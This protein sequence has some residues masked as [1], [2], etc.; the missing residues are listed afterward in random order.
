MYRRSL[1]SCTLIGCFMFMLSACQST[2]NV[3]LNPPYKIL[4]TSQFTPQTIESQ[5]EIFA[6]DDSIKGHLDKFLGAN[7]STAFRGKQLLRF[8]MENGDN[9]L[10]YQSGSNLT[11]SETF[12][13]LNANCLSLSILAHSMS[14]YIG[15]NS[16]FQQVHIPEF[17][18]RSQGYS[19]LTGHVNIK[20][21]P[22]QMRS[23]GNYT[24]IN[25]DT[26][27]IIVDFDPNS[28]RQHFKTSVITK[29]RI[30]SMFYN[31]KGALALINQDYDL[32]Y[33][34][35]KAAILIDPDY[36]AS[37][38]NIGVLYRANLDFDSAELA[39]NHAVALSENYT[40]SGNLALLYRLTNREADAIVIEQ[41]IAKKR[42]SNPYYHIM[43]G[44]EAY[45]S[46]DLASALIAYRHAKQL[47][48]K[49]HFS[50]FGIAKIYYQQGNLA[51][52]KHNLELARKLADFSFEKERYDSKLRWLDAMAKN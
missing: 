8:L 47:D 38:G 23:S 45:D 18:D 19:L 33:S 24:Y 28:R 27:A 6:L 4:N 36:S 46:N 39:Y 40:A 1:V 50:Y 22:K 13:N 42:E 32:A 11:A 49:L 14:E 15:L 10:A 2:N 44:N 21:T 26:D 35:F 17:W 3:A 29:D 12:R 48:P 5:E 51:A 20:V 16:T 52:A 41:R 31:N 34:Y 25:N 43:L 37:W 7:K 30:T 9:S